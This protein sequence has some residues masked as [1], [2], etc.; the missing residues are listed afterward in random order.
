MLHAVVNES[1][2][3]TLAGNVAVAD[4]AYARIMGLMGCRIDHDEG[5][6][7]IP[8]NGIHMFFMLT[9][10][11]AVFVSREW[12]VVRVVRELKPWRMV[13][14]VYKAHAVLELYPGA[15][16]D[17]QIGDVLTLVKRPTNPTLRSGLG[18]T[19]N[20]RGLARSHYPRWNKYRT[21]RD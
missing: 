2:G 5:L 1:S 15:A 20:S 10:I 4:S 17:V 3:A 8:C 14:F 21:R 7:I 19:T 9:A 12:R 13:P 16:R 18:D 11:D 6:L